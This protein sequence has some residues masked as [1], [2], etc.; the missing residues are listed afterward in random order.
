MTPEQQAARR[1]TGSSPACGLAIQD[2]NRVDPSAA[3]GIALGEAPMKSSFAD[4]LLIADRRP[5]ARDAQ[6]ELK[7][8]TE[9]A[10]DTVTEDLVTSWLRRRCNGHTPRSSCARS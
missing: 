10:I 9:Q 7:R 8:V 1:S 5:A 4:Y 3:L 6:L 2:Y